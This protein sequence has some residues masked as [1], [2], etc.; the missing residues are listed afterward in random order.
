MLYILLAAVLC[1]LD[2]L[3]KYWV[4]GSIGLGETMELLPGVLG[5]THIKNTGMAFSL[6]SEHTW[7]LAALSAVVTVL[8]GVLLLRRGFTRWEKVAL[9]LVMGGAAGNA[10]DRIFL[11]YVVDMFNLEFVNF[12]VFN[13][14]DVFIDV[15][16]VLFCVLYIVRVSREDRKK[17]GVMPELQ[18]LR[19]EEGSGEERQKSGLPEDSRTGESGKD[20]DNGD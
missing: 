4:S 17:R 2:Q 20:E 6:L 13:L 9:A 1:G 16:A 3:L 14:A 15:G 12:A 7:L 10:I 5:L 11:G 19:R 8:I 18:R